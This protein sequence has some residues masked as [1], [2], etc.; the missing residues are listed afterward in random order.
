[1]RRDA[2]P[3]RRAGSIQRRRRQ[4]TQGGGDDGEGRLVINLKF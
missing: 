1:M 2:W 4:G 3:R